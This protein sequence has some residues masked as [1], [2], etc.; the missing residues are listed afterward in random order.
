LRTL[1]AVVAVVGL[2]LA[3]VVREAHFRA[4]LQRE[5]ARAEA[6]FRAAQAAVDQFYAQVAEQWAATGPHDDQLRRESSERTARS[7]RGKGPRASSP[8]EK[9]KALDR[10][11]GLRSKPE[12]KERSE[13]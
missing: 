7:D 12:G 10:V 3:V 1:L 2:L 6:N 4:E 11:Q 13:D 9:T 8:D 5:R